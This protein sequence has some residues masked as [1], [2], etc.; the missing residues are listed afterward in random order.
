MMRHKSSVLALAMVA[1]LFFSCEK[2]DED[3]SKSSLTVLTRV[4]LRDY[5]V[6]NANLYV[7][8]LQVALYAGLKPNSSSDLF[9]QDL[10][11]GTYHLEMFLSS[12]VG[13][14]ISNKVFQIY[15]CEDKVIPYN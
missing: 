14:G 3:C 9:V 13:G 15:P 2:D 12:S 1:L 7:A 6:I 11:L 10:L 5:A 4:S 8:G